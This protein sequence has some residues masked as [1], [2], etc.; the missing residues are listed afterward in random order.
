MT[1]SAGPSV[2]TNPL[3]NWPLRE[4]AGGEKTA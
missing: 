2:L 4:K 3:T 1:E